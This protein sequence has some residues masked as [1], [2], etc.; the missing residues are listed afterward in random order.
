MPRQMLMHLFGRNIS[1]TQRA[2][3]S[4]REMNLST[5]HEKVDTMFGA[6]L[7]HQGYGSNRAY[8]IR[9]LVDKHSNNDY[10]RELNVS[11]EHAQIDIKLSPI[12]HQRC[13]RSNRTI[14]IISGV[15]LNQIS[16][17]GY[18]N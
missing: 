8:I 7:H 3:S 9:P 5:D 1:R 15:T 11:T 10:Y 12:M 6:L 16:S 2:L 13:C 14:I 4:T 18:A 17:S